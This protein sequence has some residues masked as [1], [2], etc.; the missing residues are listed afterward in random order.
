MLFSDS[1][2]YP[3]PHGRGVRSKAWIAAL[4]RGRF[5][6]T[7][8]FSFH[9][10][11]PLSLS[12]REGVP[13]HTRP[14]T[15]VNGAT[16]PLEGS[17]TGREGHLRRYFKSV[18]GALPCYKEFAS[19]MLFIDSFPR[20]PFHMERGERIA[21]ASASMRVQSGA[22]SARTKN[23]ETPSGVSLFFVQ[24]ADGGL[25]LCPRCGDTALPEKGIRFAH[26]I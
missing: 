13:P 22:Q 16:T 26:A 18:S 21:P 9:T 20:P 25:G 4:R 24:T 5:A 8:S 1:Y 3:L 17:G 6:I 19:L 14:F 2:P 23:R 11:R 12:E 15:F 7:Y 10:P